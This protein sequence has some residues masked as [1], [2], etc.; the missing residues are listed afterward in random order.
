VAL[1]DDQEKN[2]KIL[3]E[4][5]RLTHGNDRNLCFMEFL[6]HAVTHIGGKTRYWN[7]FQSERTVFLFQEQDKLERIIRIELTYPTSEIDHDHLL[8]LFNEHQ[9]AKS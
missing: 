4:N 1:Q 9:S 7:V 6:F 2:L 5:P 3:C 8:Q